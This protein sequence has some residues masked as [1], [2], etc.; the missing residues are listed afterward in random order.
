MSKQTIQTGTGVADDGTVVATLSDLDK[1]DAVYVLVDDNAGG[2]P[3]NYDLTYEV[4]NTAGGSTDMLAQSVSG[5]TSR[6]HKFDALPFDGTFTL[7][8]A[9]GGS[10]DYQLRVVAVDSQA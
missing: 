2:T 5:A 10:A 9:S 1:Y 7:T 6:Y 8:N 3:A 4:S